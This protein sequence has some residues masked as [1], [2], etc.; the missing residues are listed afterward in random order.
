VTYR[1]FSTG[2]TTKFSS[3]DC[4]AYYAT[5]AAGSPC[6]SVKTVSFAGKGE[7]SEVLGVT[8]PSLCVD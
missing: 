1:D 7:D 4:D 6:N 3:Y 8:F 2:D 5:A